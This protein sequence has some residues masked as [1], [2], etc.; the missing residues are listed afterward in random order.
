M[1]SL[2][3]NNAVHVNW[4]LFFLSALQQFMKAV[5]GENFKDILS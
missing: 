2:I 1:V 5:P 3:T 4:D